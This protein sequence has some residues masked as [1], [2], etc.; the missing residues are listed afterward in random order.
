MHSIKSLIIF[1]TFDN[2]SCSAIPITL[3]RRGQVK[4]NYLSLAY[5]DLSADSLRPSGSLH[6]PVIF[7]PR[8]GERREER[9]RHRVIFHREKSRKSREDPST[10]NKKR[11]ENGRMGR[12]GGTDGKLV[13][14]GTRVSLLRSSH[15][16]GYSS[17]EVIPR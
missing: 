5:Y 9:K 12:E 13:L 7:Y 3:T 17:F 1:V 15:N 11:V 14:P 8:H 10:S 6:Q 2:I 16:Q 4:R